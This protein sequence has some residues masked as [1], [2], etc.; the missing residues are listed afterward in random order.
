[1]NIILDEKWKDLYG[2][3]LEYQ[4]SNYGRVRTLNEMK[5]N[6]QKKKCVEIRRIKYLKP[7]NNGK[8]YM[9]VIFKKDGKKVHKYIHRLVAESFLEKEENKNLVNHKDYD[10]ANNFVS[11]LEWC[12]QKENVLYSVENMKK[13][14]KVVRTSTGEKYITM[15]NGRY[16]VNIFKVSDKTFKTLEDAISYRDGILNDNS[17]ARK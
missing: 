8:G 14:K 9:Y 2:Y 11:N 13:P 10:K 7:L 15:R 3:D 4:V 16:R 17:F 5:Y 1:M 6:F 12:T